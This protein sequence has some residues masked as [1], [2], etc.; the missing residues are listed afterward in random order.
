MELYWRKNEKE[1]E[2]VFDELGEQSDNMKHEA[3]V[4]P[5][6]Q[7]SVSIQECIDMFEREEVL[8]KDN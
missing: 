5:Y 6:K 7:P 8:G 2:K 4:A 1:V 3:G